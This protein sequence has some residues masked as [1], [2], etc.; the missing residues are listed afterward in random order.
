MPAVQ[1]P[2]QVVRNA[3]GKILLDVHKMSGCVTAEELES[4]NEKARMPLLEKLANIEIEKNFNT[5]NARNQ[6][7]QVINEEDGEDTDQAE[8]PETIST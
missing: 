6:V 4:I 8:V 1:H 5:N 2:N 3:S 7:K